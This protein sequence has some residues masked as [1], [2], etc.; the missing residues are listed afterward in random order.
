MNILII[1]TGII[2]TIYGWALKEAGH[3]VT[4]LV[5]TPKPELLKDGAKMDLI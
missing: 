1:G 5:R 4:H 2:G 3:E